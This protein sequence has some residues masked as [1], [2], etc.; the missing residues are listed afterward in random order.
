MA[1]ISFLIHP[2]P[3]IIQPPPPTRGNP[4]TT[5]PS[6]PPK[7]PPPRTRRVLGNLDANRLHGIEGA[8]GATNKPPNAIG[9]T[10]EQQPKRTADDADLDNESD[11]DESDDESDEGTTF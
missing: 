10:R 6:A 4:S 9:L 7:A 3:S 8:G 1:S 5:R 2:N 11:D